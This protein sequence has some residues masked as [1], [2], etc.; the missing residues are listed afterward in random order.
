MIDVYFELKEKKMVCVGGLALLEK[1]KT[2]IYVWRVYKI[3]PIT[4][5]TVLFQRNENEFSVMDGHY[6]HEMGTIT[7]KY[8]NGYMNVNV[9]E[10]KGY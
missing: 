6:K 3:Y 4:E 10:K 8:I 9:K 2:G 5:R 7:I 1:D